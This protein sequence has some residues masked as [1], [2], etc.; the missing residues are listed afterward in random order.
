MK[1]VAYKNFT[2]SDQFTTR[3][4]HIALRHWVNGFSRL[5]VAQP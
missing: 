2:Q 1:K 4:D 3:N 5:Y